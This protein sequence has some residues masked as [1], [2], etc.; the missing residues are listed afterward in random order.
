MTEGFLS[1]VHRDSHLPLEIQRLSEND[2]DFETTAME[3]SKGITGL[4]GQ[5]A[6]QAAAAALDQDAEVSRGHMV[7]LRKKLSH[8]SSHEMPFYCFVHIFQR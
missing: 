1:V 3:K 6:T 7:L 4:S 5:A 8:Q 2:K